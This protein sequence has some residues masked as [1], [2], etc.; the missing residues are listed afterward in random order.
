MAG[1]HAYMVALAGSYQN[2]SL[3]RSELGYLGL[4]AMDGQ[5][6]DQIWLFSGSRTPHI[7]RPVPH[8]SVDGCRRFRYV[9]ESYI[10][11]IMH[12]EAVAG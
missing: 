7:L 1:H 6:G 10:H 2:R 9:G 5:P 4:C 12:G 11:G 3:L 8:Q